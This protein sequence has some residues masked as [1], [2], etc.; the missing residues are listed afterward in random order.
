M[1]L[2]KTRVEFE[3]RFRDEYVPVEEEEVEAWA[4][5][6]RLNV[7]GKPVSR[8]DAKS[9]VTGS[10]KYT[11]DVYPPGVLYG[12]F[13]RSPYSHAKVKSVNI[14]NALETPGV[15][16]IYTK[17]NAHTLPFE[18]AKKFFGEE[19]NYQG[20]EVAFVVAEEEEALSD[21]IEKID[22]EYEP[23]PAFL[24][25]EE[26]TNQV[27]RKVY[28]RGSVEKG[29]K[30]ADVVIEERFDTQATLHN[31]METHGC[32]VWWEG[33][34]LIVHT[35]TQAIFYVRKELSEELGIP[36]KNIRVICSFMGGGF[37]SKFGAGRYTLFAAM[38][39]R[40][41]SRAVRV[42]LD[43]V[44]ENLVTGNRSQTVQKI[45]IGAKKDGT[46]TAIEHFALVNIGVDGW[47]ADVG[48]PTKSLY[49]C[50]NVRVEIV[51]VK[52]NLVSN[53][54][55]RA[56][57]YVEGNFALECALDELA[58]KLGI[59][60]LELRLRNYAEK[61]QLL[62][63]PYSSKG[64]K[65]AYEKGARLIRWFDEPRVVRIGDKIRAKGMASVIWFG[66]GGPPAYSQVKL[67]SDGSVNVI[68]ATQD[69]GTGTKTALAQIA[70][71]ELS[72]PIEKVQV[73]LGDT[74]TELYSPG[75]GGSQT[76]ASVGPAVR[77][78]ARDVKTQLLELASQ[79]FDAPLGSLTLEN[80]VIKKKT[81]EKLATLE[82]I[83]KRLGNFVIIGKGARGPNKDE[84]A[85]NTFAAQFAEIEVDTQTG[86]IK[87]VK[88][89][90]VHDSGR[91]VNP[92][93]F[94]SQIEG[95]VIQGLGYALTEGRL[96]DNS[97]AVLNP[98]LAD[99]LIPCS[100]DIGEI[101]AEWVE[102]QDPYV[103]NIGSKGI[104]EPPII[105]VAPAIANALKAATGVRARALPLTPERVYF[106]INSLLETSKTNA[107]YI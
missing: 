47:T 77:S 18:A 23:L 50:E 42:V 54:A 14:Q 62:N 75:S 105:G 35:S 71:E 39:S 11:H 22:V 94:S 29:F 93:V 99:Y 78:A 5:D 19:V 80:G 46:L 107:T 100:E 17:H 3:G 59:D 10:A 69:I 27:T 45:R 49:R 15:V 67:N 98:N 86:K 90:S 60:P 76:L 53:T 28:E 1:K 97:G 26:P 37:G 12:K 9:K 20:E 38:V 13:V 57:G 96:V 104:G 6:E 70:A 92:L 56:P 36:E 95:G 48:G 102:V 34:T 41:L 24:N 103:N 87:L 66:G 83:A 84:Y 51:G 89:V 33:D 2:V 31:C 52:T 21:A 81:G 65:Q 8:V 58:Q 44:E 74:I 4:S 101:I 85:L 91:V 79:L 73:T 55:F 82:E 40:A 68:T 63:L 16:A 72:I 64:L 32:V 43:R 25:I 88:F 7:V 61:D 30:E 106:S